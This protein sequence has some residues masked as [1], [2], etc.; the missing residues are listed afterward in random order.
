MS[1][2]DLASLQRTLL[3]GT[4]SIGVDE[5]VA[6]LHRALLK[7]HTK[8]MGE[9]DPMRMERIRSEPA[10]EREPS[11]DARAL[12]AP[13]G[14]RR[15]F[16]HR[17][18]ESQGIPLDERPAVWNQSLVES[19]QPMVRAG[20]MLGFYLDDEGHEIA[21]PEGQSGIP[22]T[23]LA[24]AKSFV[25]SG[26]TFLPGAVANGGWL[27]SPIALGVLGFFNAYCIRLL[28]QCSEKIGSP[29]FADI[30]F[31]A[32]GNS[33]KL[34]VQVSLV[35]SQFAT[36]IAYM[37]FISRIAGSLG[38][39]DYLSVVQVVAAQLLFLIPLCLIRQVHRLELAILGADALIFFGL[40]VILWFSVGKIAT[41]GT[42]PG[43][44][45]FR[46][47]T[48]GLFIGTAIFTFEGIPM[49]LPVKQAMAEPEQYWGWFVW[50]FC[51]IVAFFMM[52]SLVGYVAFGDEVRSVVILNLPAT[53]PLVKAVNIAYAFALIL[54]SPLIFLPAGKIVE[55]WIFGTSKQKGQW[56]WSKNALRAAEFC[57][58]GVVSV[59]GGSSFDKFV[60]MTGALC[61]API[62]LIYPPWFHWKLCASTKAEK[63]IDGFFITLGLG[64]GA[65][66]FYQALAL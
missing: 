6:D 50:M 5:N 24:I 33:G 1:A 31:K 18:A 26:I 25:G 36:N 34:A 57:I 9:L 60:A 43:L 13:G 2:D 39:Q 53:D 48:C 23:L 8:S 66:V 3:G 56:K 7:E 40:F 35:I 30:A 19:L 52:F 55:L 58:F 42:G 28:L 44:E 11:A 16:L 14:F 61:C 45:P 63:I 12:K 27:F 38:I 22:A 21:L 17:L 32:V 47:E 64:S 41:A 10:V 65:L 54:G 62:A 29:S 46:P 49:V 59:L 4:S 20:S 51:G 15:G 37:I